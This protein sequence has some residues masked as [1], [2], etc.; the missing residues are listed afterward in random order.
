VCMT[1]ADL[2]PDA[3][4]PEG[5]GGKPVRYLS[6]Q[7][8]QGVDAWLEEVLAGGYNE[9]SGFLDID[10]EQYARAE[11]ALAWL[12]LSMRFEPQQAMPPVAAAGQLMDGLAAALTGVGVRIVH[13]KLMNTTASGWIKAAQCANGEEPVVEG[14]L[15]AS[16]AD[17]HEVLLNLR[18]VGD[19]EEVEAIVR[20]EV[21]KMGGRTEE[22]RVDCFS[23]A[24]PRPER[25]MT[26]EARL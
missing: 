17:V 18:A 6:A 1:K 22:L 10:Y 9:S 25:R 5:A 8:G 26:K 16:P 13:L 19:P 12:N 2:Y 14:M 11:A 3:K 24:P 4:K 15:D 7:T 23:P 21:R 20:A